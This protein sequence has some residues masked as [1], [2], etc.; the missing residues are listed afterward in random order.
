MRVRLT[1]PMQAISNN[2]NGG[3]TNAMGV[4]ESLNVMGPPPLVIVGNEERVTSRHRHCFS[5]TINLKVGQRWPHAPTLKTNS[6]QAYGAR[7][8]RSTI[9]QRQPSGVVC[10]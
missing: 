10:G 3:T 5:N 4:V 8:E 2:N 6:E 7:E 9:G 1:Q